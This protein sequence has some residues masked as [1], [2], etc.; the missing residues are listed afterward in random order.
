MRRF[1]QEKA[2]KRFANELMKKLK[3]YDFDFKNFKTLNGYF[4]FSFSKSSV[5]HFEVNGWK[6]G[7]WQDTKEVF[8]QHLGSIDKFKPSASSFKDK[9]ENIEDILDFVYETTIETDSY[10]EECLDNE[11]RDR[12]M[13]NKVDLELY[14]YIRNLYGVKEIQFITN[15]KDIFDIHRLNI[16]LKD[17]EIDD[18]KIMELIND[19]YDFIYNK[20]CKENR[21]SHYSKFMNIIENAYRS[22]KFYDTY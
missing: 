19:K 5:I 7:V 12:R 9:Y 2:N 13:V 22:I 16:I 8:A 18:E 15:E 11:N 20:Y 10:G 21:V 3:S 17:K 6:F 14:Q 4:I 1:K